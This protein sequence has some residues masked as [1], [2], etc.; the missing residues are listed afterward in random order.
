MQITVNT[1]NHIHGSV[2][3]TRRVEAVLE[4]SLGRF[5][6]RIT[7]VGVH[8]SDENSRQ[9]SGDED[10]RCVIEAR[11]AGLQPIIVSD[12]GSSA[13]QA[14]DGAADKLVKILD[15]TLGRLDDPKGRMSYAGDQT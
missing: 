11:L 15:R 7:R 3:L 14:L 6:E 2:E 1:D 12:D 10:K 8:L 5:A 13:A 9:K 4:D